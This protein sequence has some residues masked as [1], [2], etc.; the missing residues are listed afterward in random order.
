[1]HID[2][3]APFVNVQKQKIKKSFKIPL[4]FTFYIIYLIVNKIKGEGCFF[5]LH[6]TYTILCF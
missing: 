3:D 5:N 6:L 4:T 2:D 1:M